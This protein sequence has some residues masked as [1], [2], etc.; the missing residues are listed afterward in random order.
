MK[1]AIITLVVTGAVLVC[2]LTLGVTTVLTKLR[3]Y[4]ENELTEG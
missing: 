2:A 1:V 4:Q 3:K